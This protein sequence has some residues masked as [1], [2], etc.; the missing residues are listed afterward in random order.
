MGRLFRKR[1]ELSH[2]TGEKGKKIPLGSV[3]S[4]FRGDLRCRNL[5]VFSKRA[6]LSLHVERVALP[7]KIK[8]LTVS[9]KGLKKLFHG[10]FMIR[11]TGSELL[12]HGLFIIRITGSGLLFRQ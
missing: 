1:G 11:V 2:L 7:V 4:G 8:S 10:L 3:G 5:K 9:S 12:F 6:R